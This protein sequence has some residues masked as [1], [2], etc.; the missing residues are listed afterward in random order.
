M[1]TSNFE[2]WIEGL[3]E[4]QRQD[5]WGTDHVS[6]EKIEEQLL[7]GLNPPQREAV[8]HEKGPLLILAGAGSG[9]TRVI[10][11]RMAYLL[12]TGKVAPSSVLAITFTNKA[13]REMKER[14]TKLLGEETTQRIWVGTFHSMFVRI[15]RKHAE[16]LGFHQSFTILDTDDQLKLVKHLLQ[17]SGKD[18]KTYPPRKIVN[19]I[20]SWK[21]RLLTPELAEQ[22]IL[23]R[24]F[25]SSQEQALVYLQFYK[26]YQISLRQKAAMDFDDILMYTVQLF[27]EN[28]DILSFYQE[29]FQQILV[30]EYQDTNGAQYILTKVLAA[31]HK[32][33]CVVGDDDQSIYSFRGADISNILNFE[34][35]YKDTK[36]VKLEQN[37]RSTSRVLSAANAV[38][39]KNHQ[40]KSKKLWTAKEQGDKLL[41]YAA[42]TQLSEADFVAKEI[43]RLVE[44]ESI[45]YNDI[46]IL[47]RVNALSRNLEAKLRNYHVPCK[48][49]GGLRFYERRVIK[50]V[51][52]YLRFILN[53]QD[54]LAF[55]RI[56]NL[57]PRGIGEKAQDALLAFARNKG[58]DLLSTCEY[59]LEH[60]QGQGFERAKKGVA[61]FVEK[62]KYFQS[63]LEQEISFQSFM[64]K[65]EEDSGL[66]Q[67][68]LDQVDKGK[69][70]M[71]SDIEN[72]KELLTDAEEFANMPSLPSFEDDFFTLE[73]EQPQTVEAFS[74]QA[75]APSSEEEKSKL[76]FL[77]SAYLERASLYSSGDLDVSAEESVKLMTVHSAKGLEFPYV[78]VVGM[79]QGIF[80]SGVFSA[81]AGVDLE[82]LEE[83]RRLAYV[84]I[85]RAMKKLYLT[86]AVERQ[87]YG[88]TEKTKPSLFIEELPPDVVDRQVEAGASFYER[89][90]PKFE[91]TTDFSVL[92]GKTTA[93]ASLPK[94]E[95]SLAAQAYQEQIRKKQQTM[96][97]GTG[98]GV[99]ALYVGMKVKHKM[100][101]VGT[102]LQIEKVAGDA[103]LL[104][105]FGDQTKR[106]LAKTA[107]LEK[108]E[109]NE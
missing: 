41:V 36:V 102:I 93:K 80:P 22:Q 11:H 32:N 90:E 69:E 43:A 21:N 63:L 16:R 109:E 57:P 74:K 94:E 28:Q 62:I 35:D 24:G 79:E 25:S 104:L 4:N 108:A 31:K 85:T 50:D 53:P 54:A 91:K 72:L 1:S 49:Y 48:I 100:F 88:K 2:Q 44:K 98:L 96:A 83:E 38:I 13:A 18:D 37:Y 3:Q 39:H 30:D 71:R 42:K 106:L 12:L 78:F 26:E 29:K 5:F 82:S 73:Q 76:S 52:A 9:K 8:L 66:L 103:L 19:A 17:A 55:E 105:K 45:S 77:L 86:Y 23:Q 61:E 46:A 67:Y 58:M 47:Y 56:I 14:L 65:V 60:G 70:E 59:V 27:K 97:Q 15:L 89:K 6:I 10:T 101:G 87:M 40:R 81:K 33:I 20:S 64:E 95:H 51:L 92:F 68:V 75:S 34:K 107:K 99:D 7:E 84:A